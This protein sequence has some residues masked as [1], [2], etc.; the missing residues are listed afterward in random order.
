MWTVGVVVIDVVDDELFELVLIPNDGPVEQ[1]A[2]Q[3]SDP[4]FGEGVRYW[5]SDRGLENLE[6]FGTED[7]VE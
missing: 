6:A 1:F 3:G 5:G 2:A 4:S 7:L